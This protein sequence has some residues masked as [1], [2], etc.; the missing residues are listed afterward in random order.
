MKVEKDL[1][2]SLVKEFSAP[3]AVNCSKMR[4]YYLLP[5]KEIP[6]RYLLIKTYQL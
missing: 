5:K 6:Y 1:A 2:N 4:T 3:S